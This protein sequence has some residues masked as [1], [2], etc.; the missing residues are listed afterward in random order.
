MQPT[1]LRRHLLGWLLLPLLPLGALDAWVTYRSSTDTATEIFD[2]MLLGS[3]RIIGEQVRVEDGVPQTYVP[4][5]ALEMFESVYRDR[6]YYRI[7]DAS[8]RL[9][10]GYPELP[11][12]P[13]ALQ[14][15]EVTHFDAVFRDEPLRVVAFAQPIFGAPS[16]NPVL[17]EVGETLNGPRQLASAIWIRS[18]TKHLLLAILLVA[19][20]LLGLRRGLGPLLA[21]SEQ[22]RG[23]TPGS[24]EPLA[25]A[26]VTAELQPLV[27]SINDYVRRLDE[28]MSAHSRFIANASHQLRTPLTVL[29][30]QVAFGLRESD[31][32][33]KDE[34]FRAIQQ[35]V[36]HGAR[37]VHQ[38][39]AFSAA[40][41]HVGRGFPQITD[42][43]A[44]VREALEGLAVFAQNR[45]IDLGCEIPELAPI[46]GEA[47]MLRELVSNLVD[48]ALRYTPA[49]GTVTVTVKSEPKG[50]TLVIEDDGPGIP[51]EERDRV[52]E[53]FY[54]I[55]NETSDGCGLGLAIV[56]EV[57][58][59]MAAKV[60]LSD[61]PSGRGL[62]V[63]VEFGPLLA[64]PAVVAALR[65][66][67][68]GAPARAL[69]KSAPRP[70]DVSPAERSEA[71]RE[72]SREMRAPPAPVASDSRADSWS[73]PD[74]AG[75]TR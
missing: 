32:V 35:G 69:L 18:V 24:L 61:P 16:H 45:Q 3:A 75:P 55:H 39:L 5:A 36:R 41:G 67:E 11:V 71:A 48:N 2:R 10:L 17:I 8:G 62:M 72:S 22:V 68:N 52:F 51:I 74:L 60:S 38:L 33:Q 27:H 47:T 54:R 1:S 31:A 42:L 58:T 6:V 37:V 13:R 56:R 28:R 23:R 59:A 50:T 65:Q 44:T 34:A 19:L 14:P 66:A 49:G 29:G 63:T 70:T 53:R 21:L 12:P 9:L 57:A 20:L 46:A 15:E 26:G 30:T 64:Q 43:A 7:A 40:E 4:P 25:A 73:P